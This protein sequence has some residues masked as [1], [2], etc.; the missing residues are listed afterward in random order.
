MQR[1]TAE[2]DEAALMRRADLSEGFIVTL[3]D[4][5]REVA[6]HRVDAPAF[7]EAGPDGIPLDID[8]SGARRLTVTVDFA[9]PGDIG[10]AVRL[11]SPVIDQ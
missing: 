3:D 6:R 11:S 4:L 2:A 7:G 9:A 5:G 1:D 10:C 8:L